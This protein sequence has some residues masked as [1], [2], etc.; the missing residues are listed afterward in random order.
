MLGVYQHLTFRWRRKE[1]V[2]WLE[3]ENRRKFPE[4]GNI[5]NLGRVMLHTEH[6]AC[7]R[8]TVLLLLLSAMSLQ[9]GYVWQIA[10]AT[11]L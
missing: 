4:E 3:F 8:D 9:G 6:R 5:A 11:E 1:F 10:L 7:S 2:A